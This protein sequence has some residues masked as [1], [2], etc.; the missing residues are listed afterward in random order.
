MDETLVRNFEL[1][2]SAVTVVGL[3]FAAFQLRKMSQSIALREKANLASV[4]THC[5]NRYDSLVKDLPEAIKNEDVDLWWYRL[6][7]LWTEEFYF[8][9]K[10]ILDKDIFKLWVL[11]LATHYQKSPRNKSELPSQSEAHANYLREVLPGEGRITS[12]FS[13]VADYSKIEN[14]KIRAEK[15]TLLID[16]YR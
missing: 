14:H 3:I 8:F 4:V 5:A 1:F 7:D 10:S 6:W 2:A 12:F 16:E 11:E 15:I 9:E 13:R